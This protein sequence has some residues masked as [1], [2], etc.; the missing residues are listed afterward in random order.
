MD[1]SAGYIAC[2]LTQGQATYREGVRGQGEMDRTDR[3]WRIK[4][5]PEE[6]PDR[7]DDIAT[8]RA[9]IRKLFATERASVVHCTLPPKAISRTVRNIETDEIWYFLRGHGEIWLREEGEVK[10]IE[11]KITPGVCLSIPMGV[12]FQYRNVGETPLAFLCVTMPPFQS[13]EAN[14]SEVEAHWEPPYSDSL[15]P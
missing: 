13:N 12:H 2:E 7:P 10:G 6:L 4:K 9:E 11:A 8:D 3:S 1:C 15:R 5:V 14:I